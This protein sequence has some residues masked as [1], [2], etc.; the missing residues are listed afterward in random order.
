MASRRRIALA[1]AFQLLLFGCGVGLVL[2]LQ[3]RFAA[4]ATSLGLAAAWIAAA[5]AWQ[6]RLRPALRVDRADRLA[7]EGAQARLLASLLDQTPAPLVTCNAQGVLQAR[8]RAARKLFGADDVIRDPPPT[9]V[10]A[11]QTDVAT[12]RISA[13]VGGTTRRTYAV[14]LSDVLALEGPLRLAVL[15][16][17]EPEIR[18]AEA[19]A[20]R[21]LMQVLSHEIMNGLTPVASLAATTEDLLAEPDEDAIIQARAAL[22]VLSRRAEGLARFAESYRAMARLPPPSLAA[23]SLGGLVEEA[24]RLFRSQWSDAGVHLLTH[25]PAPDTQVVIDRDQVMHAL[26]NLLTNAAEAALTGSG[27]APATVE[28]TGR[29]EGRSLVLSVADTGPGVAAADREKIFTPFFT[30]KPQG[31]G[32]GL[33]LSRQIARAHGGDLEL[34]APEPDLGAVFDIRWEG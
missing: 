15:L 23:T 28:L 13:A 11:L 1:C 21:E 16:D 22:A 4:V 10:E 34:R 6:G 24:A 25:A 31:S 27:S 3:A 19:T 18:A 29:R 30:T 12:A 26:L 17:I 7:T 2:A 9:L 5:A 14:S 8:N 32:I 20:L 33:S